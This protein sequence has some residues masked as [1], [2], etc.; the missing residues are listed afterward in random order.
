MMQRGRGLVVSVGLFTAG[1]MMICGLPS[2]EAAGAPVVEKMV[3]SDTIQPVSAGELD[4]AI[5]RANADGAQALLVELDTPGGLLDSTREMVGKILGS[6]VPVIVYVSPGRAG[7]VGGVLHAG[8]GGRGGDGS[9]H[10]CGRGASGAG[11]RRQ[12]GRNHE[13]ED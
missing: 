8:G 11:V 9:G 2:A 7:G 3:L 4:R 5:A 13:P 1:L 12:A 6:R 10:E